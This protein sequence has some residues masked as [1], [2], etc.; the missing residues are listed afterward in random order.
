MHVLTERINERTRNIYPD[1]FKV[2]SGAS[3]LP[4]GNLLLC[5]APNGVPREDSLLS[6]FFKLLSSSLTKPTNVS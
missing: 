5:R 4:A 1:V 2:G 6:C 3:I